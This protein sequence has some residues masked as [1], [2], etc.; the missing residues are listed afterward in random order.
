MYLNHEGSE[1][2]E[3]GTVGLASLHGSYGLYVS[4]PY[5]LIDFMSSTDYDFSSSILLECKPLKFQTNLF[6]QEDK[7]HPLSN[8]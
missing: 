7:I 5:G 1:F 4:P 6:G 8:Y 3:S 2:K